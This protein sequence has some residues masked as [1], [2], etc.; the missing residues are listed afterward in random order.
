MARVIPT[1]SCDAFV[2]LL[3]F[4]LPRSPGA[5]DAQPVDGGAATAP[6]SDRCLDP[7]GV[8]STSSGPASQ[9]L[10]A[11]QWYAFG[12]RRHSGTVRAKR[13]RH[14]G[15]V[16]VQPMTDLMAAFLVERH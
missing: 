5:C 15:A 2:A 12:R 1:R 7:H 6:A 16:P 8:D 4:H 9:L 10:R 14:T 13:V 11:Q 3:T